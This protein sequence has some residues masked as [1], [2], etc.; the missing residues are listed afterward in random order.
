[1]YTFKIFYVLFLFL[2][3]LFFQNG[4]FLCLAKID[5]MSNCY[6]IPIN[7][8]SLC[9]SLETKLNLWLSPSAL[10]RQNLCS[11]PPAVYVPC[12]TAEQ[13]EGKFKTDF[14]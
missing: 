1:M 3:K 7:V 14:Q 11:G 13:V 12:R 4:L 9:H 5:Q 8:S 2:L 10:Q 6:R